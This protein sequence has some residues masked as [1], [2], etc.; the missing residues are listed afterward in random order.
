MWNNWCHS[1]TLKNFSVDKKHIFLIAAPA[2]A[3]PLGQVS[4][5]PSG[6][7]GHLAAPDRGGAE[8]RAYRSARARGDGAHCPQSS[9]TAQ[10]SQL[11]TDGCLAFRT[12]WILVSSQR[13]PLFLFKIMKD[14]LENL[15]SHQQIFQRIHKDRSVGGVPVHPDQLQDM[16][17]RWVSGQSKKCFSKWSHLILP[18]TYFFLETMSFPGWTLS[19]HLVASIWLKW[20]SWRTNTK[21]RPF[22][23][24]QSSRS[25]RGS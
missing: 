12:V 16:A 4:A 19:P 23:A 5:S 14:V 18:V 13:M 8:T 3:P 25:N 20:S 6:C 24:K 2:L 21:C 1:S 17:E 10:G 9:G 22:S 11:D 15:K 7:S